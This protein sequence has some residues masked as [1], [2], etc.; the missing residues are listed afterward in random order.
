M[1]YKIICKNVS[2]IWHKINV[3]IKQFKRFL[4]F[5]Q[6]LFEKKSNRDLLS[7]LVL[8]LTS[9][10]DGIVSTYVMFF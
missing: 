5:G 8:S 2:K 6:T 3:C 10:L 9:L 1:N 4:V 7:T